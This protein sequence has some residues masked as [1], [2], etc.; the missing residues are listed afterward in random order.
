MKKII[1]FALIAGGMIACNDSKTKEGENK[2]ETAGK[3]TVKP[4]AS[5]EDATMTTWLGGKMLNSTRKDPKMDMYDHLKLN[6][7]GTCTDK[8]NA[9]AKWKVEGGEFVFI[10]SME[11]KNKIEKKNDSMVVFKGAIGDDVYVL[12]P[13]K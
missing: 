10:A 3:E 7:D 9:S 4:A 12:S 5:G 6:A 2:T 13:I 8:D 11:L 1:L